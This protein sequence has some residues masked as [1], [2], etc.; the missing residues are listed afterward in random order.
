[1]DKKVYILLSVYVIAFFLCEY[2]Y[3]PFEGNTT[4]VKILLKDF[5]VRLDSYTYFLFIKLEQL[6]FV[7]VVRL[8]VKENSIWMLYAFGLAMIEYPLTYNE[9]I[10]KIM[11][12]DFW[13]WQ[14][15]IPVS[16]ATLKFSAV[17]Y[18]MW[19]CVKKVFE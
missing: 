4:E 9:P 12:P 8:F 7:L 6:I 16:T 13:G 18:F 10:A 2:M 1:M 17:C 3:L 14:P 19:G 11:L 5:S 15:Y